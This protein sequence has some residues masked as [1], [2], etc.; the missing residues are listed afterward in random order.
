MDYSFSSLYFLTNPF[1]LSLFCQHLIMLNFLTLGKNLSFDLS[2]CYPFP[3][4]QAAWKSCCL[5]T[6]WST[7]P[8]QAWN[9][10]DTH[11]ISK[12]FF[13]FFYFV[14]KKQ[15]KQIKPRF[16]ASFSGDKFLMLPHVTFLWNFGEKLLSKPHQLF[17]PVKITNSARPAHWDSL[18][19]GNGFRFN[20]IST[21]KFGLHCLF[22]GI[23]PYK[24]PCVS[25]LL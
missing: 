23:I 10:P 6:A 21:N 5:G 15:R 24:K 9:S 11:Q 1:L 25:F 19:W 16:T 12:K 20:I 18:K 4:N 3:H 7:S 17:F 13:F 14:R 22:E 2:R 8:S